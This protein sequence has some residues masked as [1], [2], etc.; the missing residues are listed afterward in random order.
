MYRGLAAFYSKEF[1][2]EIATRL[3]VTLSDVLAYND[4]EIADFLEN[5]KTDVA[6]EAA[7]RRNYVV[8]V[9]KK[10]N[11]SVLTEDESKKIESM[12]NPEENIS[13]CRGVVAFRASPV[14]GKVK[15]IN[16]VTDMPKLDLGDILVSSMTRPEFIM[17]IEL[18]SAIVTDEGGML[19]HA[20]I[21]ARELKK[22]CIIGTKIATQ[23]LHDGDLVE[24]D[25][26]NGI[27]KILG[28]AS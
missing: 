1:F 7:R 27:V 26:D 8:C 18:A 9:Y 4:Y 15:I 23:V 24:V 14:R 2:A 6:T 17:S 16:S 13:E 19:C 5:R 21:V 11:W 12:I 3:D 22:L 25:A 10:G 20:A 28:K